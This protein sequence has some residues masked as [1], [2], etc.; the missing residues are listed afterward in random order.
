[1]MICSG[2]NHTDFPHQSW[3]S[4]VPNLA[5]AEIVTEPL[6]DHHCP[7]D[8]LATWWQDYYTGP[9]PA[10]RRKICFLWHR[11]VLDINLSSVPIMFPPYSLS[12]WLH[13]P[14]HLVSD[15]EAHVT[16]KKCQQ[17][18]SAHGIRWFLPQTPS[19]RSCCFN[20][21][22]AWLIEDPVWLPVRDTWKHGILSYRMQ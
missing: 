10:W 6:I 7:V 16:A 13:T 9:L 21:T 14:H 12:W 11:Y 20:R 1:M 2:F 18:A 17:R 22:E 19:L 4:R 5:A 3:P 15:Q 8:Q